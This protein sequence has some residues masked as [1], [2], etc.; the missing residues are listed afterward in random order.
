MSR[1]KLMY[2]L[3]FMPRNKIWLFENVDIRHRQVGARRIESNTPACFITF[4][5]VAEFE[6]V[7]LELR[8][9]CA[10]IWSYTVA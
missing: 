5:K 9:Q 4:I 10:T 2:V 3:V 6:W 1:A 8:Y 7:R